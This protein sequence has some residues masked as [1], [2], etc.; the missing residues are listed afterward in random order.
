MGD[1]ENPVLVGTICG[2]AAPAVIDYL[3]PIGPYPICDVYEFNN[4]A[5]F[6]ANTSGATGSASWNMTVYVPCPDGCTLTQGYWKTH[7]WYGPAPYD[8]TWAHLWDP[9]VDPEGD[10]PTFY[11][12]GKT[13]H[14]VLLTPASDGDAY[15][16]M[17][18]QYIAAYLNV[19]NGA[20]PTV[21]LETMHHAEELLTMY[22]PEDELGE[23]IRQDFLETKDM[24][25]MYNEG[26]IGPG[27]CTE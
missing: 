13:W 1:P 10:Y 8:D 2:V 4:N 20:D 24:L 26:Y 14:E 27:H 9:L 11:N 15:I 16:I 25:E 3:T 17:A 21:I 18:Y 19:Y 6:V 5:W 22:T 12:S 7:S 23:D